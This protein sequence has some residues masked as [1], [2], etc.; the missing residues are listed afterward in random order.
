MKYTVNNVWNMQMKK[1]T[2]AMNETVRTVKKDIIFSF[3]AR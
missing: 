3:I 1:E 2:E